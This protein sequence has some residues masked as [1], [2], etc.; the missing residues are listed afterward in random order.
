MKATLLR[1]REIDRRLPTA[2]LALTAVLVVGLGVLVAACGNTEITTTVASQAPNTVTVTS[3]QA[4]TAPTQAVA[5]TEIA[6][7]TTEAAATTTPGRD[8]HSGV[9]RDVD[10]RDRPMEDRRYRLRRP[11]ARGDGD[12]NP[13]FAPAL[14]DNAT[15]YDP[16]DGAFLIERQGVHRPMLRRLFLQYFP[17]IK[18]HRQGVYLSGDAV[19]YAIAMENM[20]PPGCRS[21]RIILPSAA[22]E[23]F[24]FKDGLV[25]SWDIWFSAPPS[26]WSNGVFA[27]GKGGPKQLQEIVDRYLAAWS[28][29]DK[30]RIAALY[31]RRPS[32]SDTMRGLQARGAAAIA[33][34]G[35]KRFGSA[36]AITFK[37]IDLYAQTNGP[38]PPRAAT[39]RGAIIGVGSTTGAPWSWT[40]HQDRRGPHHLRARHQDG[41][42]LRP[43]S[44][45][46]A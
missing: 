7:T 4:T 27:P 25:A 6:T 44:I 2:I 46:M 26:R 43:P 34:L 18:A 22:L 11:L 29:G 24:R 8:H 20:W 33:D 10:G 45:P 30:A 13:Q 9:G 5:T 42:V 40:A 14:A 16:T 1:S 38:Y 19:A 37:M 17:N 28:S 35:E 36:D 21:R 31:Q 15:Y 32:F 3:T 39:H 41:E 12:V 23:V